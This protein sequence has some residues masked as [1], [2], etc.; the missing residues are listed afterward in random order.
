M[1]ANISDIIKLS[2]L[3]K[4]ANGNPS[5]WNDNYFQLIKNTERR[6][7]L[8]KCIIG[9]SISIPL[10][11]YDSLVIGI[12]IEVFIQYFYRNYEANVL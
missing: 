4:S 1:A 5:L 11:H 2:L 6:L 12:N 9:M 7:T 8:C 3:K 10:F